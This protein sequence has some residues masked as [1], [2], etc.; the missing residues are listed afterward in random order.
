ML[1]KTQFCVRHSVSFITQCHECSVP[2]V[3]DSSVKYC[4]CGNTDGTNRECERCRLIAENRRLAE[5]L[6]VVR[7]YIS[8][9]R[10]HKPLGWWVIM[11]RT[12]NSLS[13]IE[14]VSHEQQKRNDAM[15]RGDY[16]RDRAKDE[17]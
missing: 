12:V 9:K 7:G 6:R 4:A 5:L 1:P 15:E 11:T 13:D 8:A 17:R 16:L 14:T 10:Q 3:P 2:V